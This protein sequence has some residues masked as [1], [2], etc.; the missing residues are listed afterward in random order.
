MQALPLKEVANGFNAGPPTKLRLPLPPSQLRAALLTLMEPVVLVAT[1]FVK[2]PVM[3]KLQ[4]SLP[5]NA[6]LSGDCLKPSRPASL[7][8]LAVTTART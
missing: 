8:S 7:V 4:L 1:E 3:L 5:H 6:R 2:L